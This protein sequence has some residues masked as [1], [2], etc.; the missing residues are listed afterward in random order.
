MKQIIEVDKY[1]ALYLAQ[2]QMKDIVHIDTHS[3][4][5]EAGAGI[6]FT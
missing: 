2:N 1:Q 6:R 3:N 4:T 5:F